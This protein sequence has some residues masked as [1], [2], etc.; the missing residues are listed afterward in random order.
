MS[1]KVREK[2]QGPRRILRAFGSSAKGFIGARWAASDENGD[3]LRVKNG[4]APG[5]VA[6]LVLNAVKNNELYI[7]THPHMRPA[8]EKRV[9]RFLAAYRKLGPAPQETAR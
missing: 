8:L 7:F 1:P 2:L 6:D 3:A 9:E 4:M 5:D